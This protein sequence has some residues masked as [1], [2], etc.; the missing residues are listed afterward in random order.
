MNSMADSREV[1]STS[2]SASS[3]SPA[4]ANPSRSTEAMAW[5]EMIAADEPRR[6]ATF[7]LLMQRAAASLVTFGR[8]S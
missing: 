1:S 8:F 7:P 6:N 3:G 2:T 4:L 5:F